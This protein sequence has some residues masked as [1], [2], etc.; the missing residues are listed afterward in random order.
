MTRICPSHSAEAPIPIVGDRDL[1]R[2]LGGQ[3]LG[4]AFEDDRKSARIGNGLGVGLDGGPFGLGTALRLEAAEDLDH[5]R[6]EPDM[7]HHRDAA[8]AEIVDGLGDAF[9]AFHLDRGAAGLLDDARGVAERN[10]RALLVGAERHVDDDERMPGA[11]HHRL[12]VGDHHVERD[13]QRVVHAVHHHAQ[14]VADQHQIDM[15]V[16]KTRGVGVVAG[17]AHDRPRVL[18]RAD[19]GNSDAFGFGDDGH[20]FLPAW[21]RG[22]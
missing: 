17:Q 4:H 19:L 8:L 2:D 5:L 9:A 1:A 10:L 13:A 15:I 20:G 12:A 7:A 3:R 6:G 22:L 21:T 16:E 14:A 18:V 11:A